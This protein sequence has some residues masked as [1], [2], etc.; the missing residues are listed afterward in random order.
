MGVGFVRVESYCHV[1][2]SVDGF[3]LPSAFMKKES[4]SSRSLEAPRQPAKS[5]LESFMIRGFS[6]QIGMQDIGL[7]SAQAVPMEDGE[8]PGVHRT[9]LQA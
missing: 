5:Q 2:V 6:F 3:D 4:N 9:S 8:V 1:D 7:S